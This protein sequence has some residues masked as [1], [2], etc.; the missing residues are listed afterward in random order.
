M[1][2][3]FVMVSLAVLSACGGPPPAEEAAAEQAPVADEASVGAT[4]ATPTCT[5][6]NA[7]E[8]YCGQF[9]TAETCRT[10]RSCVWAFNRCSPTYE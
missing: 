9:R 7:W 6:G 4:G 3:F 1:R 10:E 8:C 2:R 5:S